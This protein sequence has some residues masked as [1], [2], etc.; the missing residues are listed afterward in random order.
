[1]RTLQ[2]ELGH[3][4]WLVDSGVGTTTTT[5]TPVDVPDINRSDQLPELPAS[6]SSWLHPDPALQP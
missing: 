2:F 1:M 4:I 3:G 5:A 6:T